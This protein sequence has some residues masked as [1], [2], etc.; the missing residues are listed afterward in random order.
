LTALREENILGPWGASLEF[1]L[2]EFRSMLLNG[3]NGGSNPFCEDEYREYISLMA[4]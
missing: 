1:L 3:V 2:Q 4:E